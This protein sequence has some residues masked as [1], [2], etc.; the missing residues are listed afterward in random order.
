V[1][2]RSTDAVAAGD[3]EVAGD[4]AAAELIFGNLDVFMSNFPLVEP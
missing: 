3:V 4:L 2:S 1:R